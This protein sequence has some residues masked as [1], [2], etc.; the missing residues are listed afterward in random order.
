M[1]LQHITEATISQIIGRI[2]IFTKKY[3]GGDKN[4]A[5]RMLPEIIKIDPTNGKYSEWLTNQWAKGTFELEDSDQLTKDLKTFHIKKSKFKNK[6]INKYT[7]KS[8][9]VAVDK[10]LELTKSE[11]KSARRGNIQLPP[12]AEIVVETTINNKLYQ[13]I[14]LTTARAAQIMCSGTNWCT[15]NEHAA[16][17]YIREDPLFLVFIDSKRTY[18]VHFGRNEFRYADNAR[19]SIPIKFK[20]I[21]LLSP[22]TGISLQDLVDP[23]KQID[24]DTPIASQIAWYYEYALGV[25]GK[26]WG[27][28]EKKILDNETAY[29]AALYAKNV[30]KGEWPKAEPFIKNEAFASFL[31]AKDV[32]RAPWYG[33]EELSVIMNKPHVAVQ[34][35]EHFIGGRWRRAEPMIANSSHA[36]EY[37][38]KFGLKFEDGKFYSQNDK[39]S[40]HNRRR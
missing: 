38:E 28:A 2:P 8:L 19:V 34:Y 3:F 16:A 10:N 11:R 5:V 18:L 35:A 15:A 1:K 25:I 27:V 13:V 6:D 37:A 36:R 31:Y 30:I 24:P 40:I 12:D 21:D 29:V 20:L 32:R 33:A 22:A 7:P 14:E 9:N 39:D 4:L 23:N 17:N 26:R